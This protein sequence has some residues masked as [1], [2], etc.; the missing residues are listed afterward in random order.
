M[1]HLVAGHVKGMAK[2]RSSECVCAEMNVYPEHFG[3]PKCS[4]CHP[5]PPRVGV[6]NTAIDARLRSVCGTLSV[7]RATRLLLD[8]KAMRERNR[9]CLFCPIVIDNGLSNK[10]FTHSIRHRA[11]F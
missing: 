7:Q 3:R 10:I 4:I 5:G 11:N 9:L 6:A 8:R 2:H 1:V